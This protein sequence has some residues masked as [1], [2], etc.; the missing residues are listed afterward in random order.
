LKN[1]KLRLLEVQFVY[2]V[3]MGVLIFL[4]F[5]VYLLAN[6]Y[7]KSFK[8]L[9]VLNLDLEKVVDDRT[10]ELTTANTVKDR[11]L[12]V[13]SHDVKSPLNS[14][15]GILRIYN[16]GDIKQE[17]F[18][19]YALQIEDDLNRTGLLVENILHWTSSQMKGVQVRKESFDLHTVIEENVDLFRTIAANKGIS[20]HHNA[21]RNTKVT[22]D[23]NVLNLVMRNLLANAI[24]YSHEGGEIQ[25]LVKIENQTLS[26]QVRDTGVG[27]DEKTMQIVLGNLGKLSAIGTGNEK[28]TGMGLALC[29]EFVLKAGGQMTVESSQGK[30]ST[31][32]VLM[33]VA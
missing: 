3:E 31:F 19:K 16:T 15:R 12:S 2:L 10:R 27:M 26:I 20:I 21:V 8:K 24:K 28:G 1:T 4:L 22:T 7:A 29:R 13:I 11:L 23:R 30:G 14:L 5:Q 33:P 6:H 9:E 17:E 25:I 32:S 18:G